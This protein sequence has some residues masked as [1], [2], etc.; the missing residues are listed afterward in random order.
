M[1]F[2]FLGQ[3]KKEI[4]VVLLAGARF[5]RR[6]SRFYDRGLVHTGRA[7]VRHAHDD[8]E[9]SMKPGELSFACLTGITTEHDWHAHM[10]IAHEISDTSK[11][12][13]NGETLD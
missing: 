6:I 3:G 5:P 10:L 1:K 4:I 12:R 9:A 11:H 2:N 7:Y 8:R 13:K